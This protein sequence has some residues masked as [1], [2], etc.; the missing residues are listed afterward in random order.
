MRRIMK[1]KRNLLVLDSVSFRERNVVNS[2]FSD[3]QDTH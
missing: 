3:L 2:D 1:K